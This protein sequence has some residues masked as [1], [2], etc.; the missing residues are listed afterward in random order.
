MD[1]SS[2]YH[3]QRS[4]WKRIS[5]GL[6][7]LLSLKQVAGHWCFMYL[8]SNHNLLGGGGG[9]RKTIPTSKKI[10]VA[11]RK[12]NQPGQVFYKSSRPF[13]VLFSNI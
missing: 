8:S 1:L 11:L 4:G 10:I 12:T 7:L 9:K 3:L 13:V 6:V 2:K 5:G